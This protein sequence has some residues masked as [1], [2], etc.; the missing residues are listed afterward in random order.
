MESDQPGSECLPPAQEARDAEAAAIRRRWITLGEALAVLAVLISA[1][2]LWNSWSE[3]SSDEASK[4][5]ET[6]QA[7]SR[8]SRLVL[9]AKAER[10]G[11]A[12]APTSP[13]QVIQEQTITFPAALGVSSVRTTGEPRIET[14]WFAQSLKQAR[15]KAGMPDNSRGDEKL[16][17][18]IETQFII[19]G[20]PH[21]DVAIYDVGY[22]VTGKWISGHNVD[23]RGVA[24]VSPVRAKDVQSSIDARWKRLVLSAKAN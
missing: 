6:R 4:S 20:E 18:A 8:A 9:T 11:L 7:A 24:R 2:T 14:G 15:E 12:L 5:A 1:L 16:P 23:L 21:T 13:D 17:V 10:R 19:A 3:R 22:T